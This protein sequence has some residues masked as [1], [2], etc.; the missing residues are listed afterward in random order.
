MLEEVS[1]RLKTGPAHMALPCECQELHVPK[2]KKGRTQP[3]VFNLLKIYFVMNT[4]LQGKQNKTKTKPTKKKSKEKSTGESR[5]D[6]GI[7][8]FCLSLQQ[9][10]S[11][12]NRRQKTKAIG[13]LS[14]SVFPSP[15]KETVLQGLEKHFRAIRLQGTNGHIC[16]ILRNS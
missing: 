8:T 5:R 15:K 13:L 6:E 9:W 2:L 7:R 12:K 10:P 4:E 14:S 1:S 11:V 16:Y 3:K